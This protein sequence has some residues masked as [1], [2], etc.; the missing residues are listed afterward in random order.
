M[1]NFKQYDWKKYNISLIIIVITISVS[2]AFILRMAGGAGDGPSLFK[3]Q[4]AGLV[5]G[6]CI[7]AFVSILDYHFVC[8]F[9]I[10]YYLAGTAMAAATKLTPLGT[11]L[12]T[13]SYRWLKLGINFQPSELCKIILILALAVFYAKFKEKTNKIYVLLLAFLITMVPTFFILIQSDLSSSMVMFFICAVMVFAAGTSYK[14]ILALLA[15][16]IPGAG[17]LLWYVQQPYQKLLD[18]YQ[19]LRIFGF[20]NPEL[21]EAADIVWQQEQSIDAIASGRVYG[22]MILDSSDQ[23]RNHLRIPVSESDFVFSVIGEELGFI[24]S[25]VLIGL[26]L[27]VILKCLLTAKKSMD[28][29]GMMIC[30]GISALFMF[31]VFANIGVVTMILPNTGLP[32]PFLSS[33]ISSMLSSMISMGIVL[34]IGLQSGRKTHNGFS[35]SNL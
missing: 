33:G 23:M 17:A 20:M 35:L 6:L 29:L 11:D 25:C 10:L 1:F 27:V 4:L 13:G 31:Q 5:L 3:K 7:M 12:K 15:I 32:L 22:K 26:L 9:V 19:Y 30:I 18:H 2:G 34:N 28:Y 16:G 21:P 8:R 24:G 14:I